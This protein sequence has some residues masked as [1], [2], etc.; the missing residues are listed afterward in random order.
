MRFLIIRINLA[1]LLLMLGMQAQAILLTPADCNVGVNC[2][3]TDVNSQP[4]ADS[5]ATLVGTSTELIE[6]YKAEVG[7]NDSGPY[8][9]SY[10]TTFLNSEL[11]PMDALIEYI[12]GPSI[13]C[14]E[15]YVSIKDGNHS[16]ALYVFDLNSWNGIEAISLEDFWPRQG[17]ISNV[18]IWGNSA[19]VPEPSTLALL[20]IGMVGLV[21]VRRRKKT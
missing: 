13:T 17:A 15:C 6:L 1:A 10:E 2:W 12:S 4:T 8:K 16:P 7:G 11:D 9:T 5:I 14:P 3:T 18:A 20:G 19:N 21:L